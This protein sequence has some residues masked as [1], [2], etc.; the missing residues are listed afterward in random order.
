MMVNGSSN[1]DEYRLDQETVERLLDDLTRRF[2]GVSPEFIL[3]VIREV[4]NLNPSAH[5]CKDS[6]F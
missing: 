3:D 4:S 6:T 1:E 2:P 5:E